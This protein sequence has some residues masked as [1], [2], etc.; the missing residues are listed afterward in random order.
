MRLWVLQILSLQVVYPV[1][2]EAPPA[3]ARG[4]YFSQPAASQPQAAF[5]PWSQVWHKHHA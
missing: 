2:L 3:T 5:P 1:G 4:L